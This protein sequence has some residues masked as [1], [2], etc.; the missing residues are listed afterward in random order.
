MTF[1]PLKVKDIRQ[2][3]SDCVSVSFAVPDDLATDFAFKQGQY[4][5]LKRT[6][7]VK[8][9]AVRTQFAPHPMTMSCG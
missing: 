2:E 6:L 1:Y 7:K 8:K 4:L 5:T 3:T 9:S